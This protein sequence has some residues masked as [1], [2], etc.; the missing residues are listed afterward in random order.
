MSTTPV[1]PDGEGPIVEGAGWGWIS[2]FPAVVVLT[3]DRCFLLREGRPRGIVE[4]QRQIFRRKS[5]I[6]CYSR[7]LEYF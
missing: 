6:Y 4:K 1:M 5:N 3:A 7:A 2:V